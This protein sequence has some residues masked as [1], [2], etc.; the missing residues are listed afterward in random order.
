MWFRL[1]LSSLFKLG[2]MNLPYVIQIVTLNPLRF[3]IQTTIVNLL[4][5][6]FIKILLWKDM[7]FTFVSFQYHA[8]DFDQTRNHSNHTLLGFIQF[9]V[10]TFKIVYIFPQHKIF[11]ILFYSSK[12]KVFSCTQSKESTNNL[13]SL[14]IA[15]N[16]DFVLKNRCILHPCYQHLILRL[17]HFELF[18]SQNFGSSH[19]LVFEVYDQGVEWVMHWCL[20][21]WVLH[22]GLH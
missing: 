11:F 19:E 10:S 14:F 17:L 5:V 12:T 9:L 1:L 15:S 7:V 18:Y 3:S 8:H 21:C 22:Q 16:I 4:I 13:L 2:T 20:C 6:L